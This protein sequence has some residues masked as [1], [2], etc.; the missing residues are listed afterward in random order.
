MLNIGKVVTPLQL[1]STNRKLI[2]FGLFF[3][4]ILPA[5]L[6]GLLVTRYGVD[7]PYYDQWDTPGR[8]FEKIHNG[9]LSLWDFTAQHNESR[10]LFPRLFFVG[11]AYLTNWN[12]RCE[13]LATFTVACLIS[14]AIYR[15]SQTTLQLGRF[16]SLGLLAVTNLL[17]FSPA[18]WENWLWG[19]QVIV[20]IPILCILLCLI[21]SESQLKFRTKVLLCAALSTL[22]TYSYAN[23]MLC[24]VAALAALLLSRKSAPFKQNSKWL[25]LYVALFIAVVSSYFYD[26]QDPEQHPSFTEALARPM[27]AIRYFMSFIGSPFSGGNVGI[28]VMPSPRMSGDLAVA[29]S[30]GIL[31]V[32][33][34]ILLSLYCTANFKRFS[35]L[36]NSSTSWLIVGS[37]SFVSALIT[38]F[39]RVSL[40]GVEQSLSSRYVTFSIYLSV[41]II[42]LSVAVAAHFRQQGYA[43]KITQLTQ[44][45]PKILSAG[46]L[47]AVITLFVALQISA[48]APAVQSM[49]T[50]MRD[51]LYLKTCLMFINYVD[52]TCKLKLYPSVSILEQ[53]AAIFN[54]MGFIHPKLAESS[55]IRRVR[56]TAS[57]ETELFGWFDQLIPFASNQYVAK[58]WATLPEQ[59]KAADSVLLTY[60]EEAEGKA[61]RWKVFT[62][63]QVQQRRDDV[64]KKFNN[65]AYRVSGWETAFSTQGLPKGQLRL[66]AWSYNTETGEAFRGGETHLIQN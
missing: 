30:V 5:L 28:F 16:P 38:T 21:I 63:A 23:G 40:G 25:G 9:T 32:T 4:A 57:A 49:Q 65:T 33:I 41:A 44:R 59:S 17:I 47:S 27:D 45:D 58:G 55:V 1:A 61:G 7:L 60:K 56:K 22:S 35:Q 10:K 13:M 24:W 42:Y 37:Y 26:Y 3:I 2:E 52:D 48:F 66:A 54:E 36:F 39:G 31:T 64:A 34:F 43:S 15:L 29:I 20:F 11:L 12:T 50:S 19:I 46:F 53:R 51:R 14:L 62:I 6:L 8:I 18:Q